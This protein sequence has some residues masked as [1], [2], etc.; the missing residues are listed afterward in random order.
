MKNTSLFITPFIFAAI[1]L[2]NS[3]QRAVGAEIT[4]LQNSAE[5]KIEGKIEPGDCKKIID[6][7]QKERA[8]KIFL[9]SPGGDLRESILIG[10]VVRNLKLHTSVPGYMDDK[11]TKLFA[12]K[13]EII[14]R[15][16]NFMCA[17]ACF[18][19]FVAGVD[20]YNA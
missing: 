12:K 4:H 13:Y 14:D 2:H 3:N 7:L 1:F 8:R 9:A 5:I 19:I 18:F 16:R 20:R 6:L 15:D 11:T 17:S 10:R